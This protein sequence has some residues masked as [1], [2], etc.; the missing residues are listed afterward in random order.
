MKV[1]FDESGFGELVLYRSTLRKNGPRRGGVKTWHDTSCAD[2]HNRAARC[3]QIVYL[4]QIAIR[5]KVG[6]SL[7]V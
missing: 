4:K 2:L 7:S 6:A 5:R 3:H 1:V